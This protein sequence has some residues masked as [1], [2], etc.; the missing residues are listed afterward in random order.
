MKKE[1]KLRVFSPSHNSHIYGVECVNSVA[2]QT[3]APF[4]HFYLDDKSED[5]TLKHLHENIGRLKETIGNRY[6]L[7]ISTTPRRKYKLLNLYDIN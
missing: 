6:N 4:D 5:G 7:R 3:Y 1:S 2:K